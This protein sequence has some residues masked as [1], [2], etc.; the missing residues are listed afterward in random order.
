MNMFFNQDSIY[1][2]SSLVELSDQAR[3]RDQLL[4]L[5][6]SKYSK[7]FMGKVIPPGV[8]QNGPIR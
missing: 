1:H 7:E 5:Y 8:C 3:Y 6:Q 4:S 2:Y